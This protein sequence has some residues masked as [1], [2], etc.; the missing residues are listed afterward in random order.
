MLSAERSNKQEK[1]QCIAK[2]GVNTTRGRKK[3]SVV[4]L[5]DEACFKLR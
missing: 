1:Q 4:V 2:K 3:A 5:V